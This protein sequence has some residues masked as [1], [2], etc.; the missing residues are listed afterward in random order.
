MLLR[1]TETQTQKADDVIYKI[2][3][4]FCIIINIINFDEREDL[5]RNGSEE[6]VKLIKFTFEQTGFNVIDYV[7]LTDV[8]V[9]NKID[10]QVNKDQCKS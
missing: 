3:N 2:K 8:L 1:M 5:K 9:L 10:E 7:D 4:G 6:S